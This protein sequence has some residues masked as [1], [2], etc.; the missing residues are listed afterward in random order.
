MI[1]THLTTEFLGRLRAFIRGRV[2]SDADAED[3][4]QDVLAK[5]VERG[6]AVRG[7]IPAW[8]FTVA[9]RAIIDRARARS[10]AARRE[11]G[12][13]LG[14]VTDD[15]H[16]A[17]ELARCLLPMLGALDEADR[18]LLRRADMEGHSQAEIAREMKIPLSTV[19]S[20]I[21]RARAK[22]RAVLADCCAVATDARGRPYHFERRY[23]KACPG[24]GPAGGCD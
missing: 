22:L 11:R 24:C 13:A 21:Q 14:G 12:P 4:L 16:A 5:L 18:E 7:S 17:G 8:I 23:G 9:R 15:A 2:E 20:R 10:A 19:R 6:G 3:L 1:D